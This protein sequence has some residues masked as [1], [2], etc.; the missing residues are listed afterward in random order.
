MSGFKKRNRV[1][2][3]CWNDESLNCFWRLKTVQWACLRRLSAFVRERKKKK[4]VH[5]VPTCAGKLADHSLNSSRIYRN[6]RGLQS[7][8][9]SALSRCW[10]WYVRRTYISDKRLPRLL[11]LLLTF[12]NGTVLKDTK[13]KEKKTVL[14]G[15]AAMQVYTRSRVRNLTPSNGMTGEGQW[16]LTIQGVLIISFIVMYKAAR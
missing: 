13:K 6:D 10:D 11:R 2:L 15:S 12:L 14:S 3:T 7:S 4:R 1:S 9:A 16:H 8:T 5:W